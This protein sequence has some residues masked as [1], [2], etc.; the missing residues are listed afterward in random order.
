MRSLIF[1]S[2]LGMPAGL[3]LVAATNLACQGP[4]STHVQAIDQAA[5]TPVYFAQYGAST[6]AYKPRRLNPSVDGSLFIT[7]MHWRTWDARRAVGT[8]VAHVNDC[9]P[10]CADGHYSTH[11]VTVRLAH[12]R[13]RC[14]SRFFTTISVR[15]SGYHTYA[16]RPGVGC[17]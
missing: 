11:R 16:R 2:L 5:S 14:G 3:L 10:D 6:H 1:R 7:Q 13:K 8:G 4:T 15:G 12:P 17:Q 9:D